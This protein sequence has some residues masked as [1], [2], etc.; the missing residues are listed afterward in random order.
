[1]KLF[2]YEEKLSKKKLADERRREKYL[3][4]PR[5]IPT[6][7]RRKPVAKSKKPKRAKIASEVKKAKKRL[8]ELCRQVTATRY[9]DIC[10]TCDKPIAGSNRQLGHFIPNSVGGAILRYHLDNLRW[11]CYYD[12]INLGGNGSEFYPRLVKEIGQE[13][14]D[15]LFILKKKFIKADLPYYLAKIAE[16]EALL[17]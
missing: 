1:M 5:R 11:Q 16:Y 4:K 13:R 2:T 9:K 17:K 6:R 7:A 8:W 14:V 10:F 12:N 3:A 15:N